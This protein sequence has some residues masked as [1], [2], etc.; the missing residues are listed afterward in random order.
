MAVLVGARKIIFVAQTNVNSQ[1]AP[2]FPV[3]L[4]ESR[5]V[6]PSQTLADGRRRSR[7][8]V[9]QASHLQRLVIGEREDVIESVTGDV[10]ARI[11]I[12]GRRPQ[13]RTT[14][15]DGVILVYPGKSLGIVLA[16]LP[17]GLRPAGISETR[18]RR[19]A[20]ARNFRMRKLLRPSPFIAHGAVLKFVELV[21]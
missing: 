8:R 21:P 20:Y 9:D 4:D 10:V 6:D 12:L 18:E 2:Y 13:H 7:S 5:K 14:D 17:P 19:H 3:V 1:V 16:V 11:D 15:L